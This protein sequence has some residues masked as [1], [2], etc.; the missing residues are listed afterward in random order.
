MV[1]HHTKRER[2]RNLTLQ[3]CKNSEWQHMSKTIMLANSTLVHVSDGS[4]GTT[5]KAKVFGSTFRRGELSVSSAMLYSTKMTLLWLSLASSLRG[6]RT[7]S[8]SSLI[9]L[10]KLSRHLL[11]LVAKTYLRLLKQC[12]HQNQSRSH[13]TKSPETLRMI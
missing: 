5:R 12:T 6:R 11:R 2:G 13:L 4:L 10:Q 1:R 3:G 9:S 7:R 8:S